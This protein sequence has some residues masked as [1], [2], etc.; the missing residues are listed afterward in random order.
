MP[1][2]YESDDIGLIL[3]FPNKIFTD[4]GT[5]I[6]IFDIDQVLLTARANPFSLVSH[7]RS[8]LY[9]RISG[10]K[11]HVKDKFLLYL[12]I[13]QST[14]NIA[15]MDQ[16]IPGL[17]RGLQLKKIKCMGNTAL[18]AQLGLTDNFD[19]ARARIKLLREFDISFLESFSDLSEWNFDTLDRA[20]IKNC[21]PLFKDGVVF[22]SLVPKHITQIELLRKFKHPLKRIAFIDDNINHLRGMYEA[23]N[24]IGVQ[25]YCFCY[26]KKNTTPLTEYFLP[27]FLEEEF[28]HLEGVIRKVL[29]DE[30]VDELFLLGHLKEFILHLRIEEG[31]RLWK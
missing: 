24:E 19:M 23:M 20:L 2:I 14:D 8:A 4:E 30:D 15:L 5:D 3:S 1:G 11:R 22:S 9:E 7:K 28:E 31:W 10:E 6:V 26:T 16:R 21:P 29:N 13:S 27:Q 18:D 12:F 25:C 17:I